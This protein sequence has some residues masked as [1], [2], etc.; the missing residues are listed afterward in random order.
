MMGKNHVTQVF[1]DDVKGDEINEIR[2]G[3]RRERP[4]SI[5]AFGLIDDGVRFE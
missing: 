3:K 4:L 2:K 1:Y 5:T